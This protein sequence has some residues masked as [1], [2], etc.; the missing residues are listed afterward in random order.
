MMSPHGY[1]SS[2]GM[3]AAVRPMTD[4]ERQALLAIPKPL[5][6]NAIG[7]ALFSMVM[8]IMVNFV[9]NPV[10]LLMPLV[11]CFA[12]LGLAVQARKSA[13][14]VA[15][16]T[17]KGTVTDVR[18]TPRWVKTGGVDFGAFSVPRS[19]QMKRMLA[20][21][22]PVT[23]TILPEAKRLLSVNGTI[24]KTPLALIAPAGFENTLSS[25]ASAE[26]PRQVPA[27]VDPQDIPPPPDDW[28]VSKCPRCGKTL[29]DGA[30][31]CDSCGFKLGNRTF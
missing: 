26:A 1:Q 25:Y 14:T 31:F 8:A 7:M 5:R 13:G 27:A 22:V 4:G 2:P 19:N 29:A 21:G 6:K 24:L 18:G 30:V 20:D 15:Q 3:S 10:A 12:G 11:F 17:A 9:D 28:A 16:A 23:V